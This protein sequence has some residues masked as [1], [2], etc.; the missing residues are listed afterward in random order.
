M[1]GSLEN[2]AT[3]PQNGRTAVPRRLVVACCS[4]VVVAAAWS[5]WPLGELRTA[6]PVLDSNPGPQP[7][8]ARAQLDV[9]AFRAPVWI[10]TSPPPPLAQ[11]PPPPP[12]PA[13]LRV[14]LLAIMKEPGGYRAALYETDTDRLLVVSAGEHVSGRVVEAVSEDRVALRDDRGVRTLTLRDIGD[15]P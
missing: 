11:A 1:N 10:A 8:Q 13:P 12:P 2:D 9:S 14:Q 6:E 15:T 5:L 4:A 7:E 3:P